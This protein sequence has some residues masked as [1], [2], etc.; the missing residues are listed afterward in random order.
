MWRF[1]KL[2]NFDLGGTFVNLGCTAPVK[3]I[4]KTL[5]SRGI[6]IP[7]HII[8]QD[9]GLPK[10]QH[11]SKLFQKPEVAKQFRE[12]NN[13]LFDNDRDL[14]DM[15]KSYIENQLEVLQTNHQSSELVPGMKPLIRYLKQHKIKICVTSGYTRPMVNEIIKGL[16]FQGFVPDFNISSSEA[17]SRKEMNI[18]CCKQF[19][20]EFENALVVG[21]TLEDVKGAQQANMRFIG[22]ESQYCTREQFRECGANVSVPNV[23]HI[24]KMMQA[25]PL[26]IIYNV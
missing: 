26:D 20:M 11:L 6:F 17:S 9:M 3:A 10:L 7:E 15:F 4:D 13:R 12:I 21:D 16:F 5:T 8:R 1:L 2:V 25:Q 23:S 19:G 22:I 24:L 14:S 18:L